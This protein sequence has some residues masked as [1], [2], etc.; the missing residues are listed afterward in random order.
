MLET[1]E[2]KRQRMDKRAFVTERWIDKIEKEHA[3]RKQ[4]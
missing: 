3:Q 1:D 4:E 2:L